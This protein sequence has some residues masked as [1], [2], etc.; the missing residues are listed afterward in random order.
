MVRLIS[1]VLLLVAVVAG[2]DK[3]S[4]DG[5]PGP[6]PSA[7]PVPSPPPA[8]PPPPP[9]PPANG[10]RIR[11][12]EEVTGVFTGPEHTF[13]LEVQSSGTLVVRLNWDMWLNG[14]LLLLRVGEAQFF[15]YAPVTGRIQVTAGQTYRLSITGGGTDWWYDEKFVLTTS[16][17]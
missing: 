4:D 3:R 16:M 11:V 13:D 6:G 5:L 14:S 7:V 15:S 12:G 2:C 10:Q 8:P 17:E 9:P 1:T